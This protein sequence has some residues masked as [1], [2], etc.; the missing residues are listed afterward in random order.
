MKIR[1]WLSILISSFEHMDWWPDL[2]DL[3]RLNILNSPKEDRARLLASK[4]SKPVVDI[5][6][7]IG[8]RTDLEYIEDFELPENPTKVAF[9]EVDSQLLLFTY[10]NQRE[11][12]AMY[13]HTMATIRKNESMGFCGFRTKA[14]WRLGSPEK[15]SRAITENFGVGADSLDDEDF[16]RMVK[17]MSRMTWKIKMLL[18]FAL[19]TRLFN[20]RLWTELP[21]FILSLIRIHFRFVTGLTDSLCLFEYRI[22]FE[23]FRMQ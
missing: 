3:D 6:V 23:V 9:D 5:M 14:F 21:I 18:L 11:G 19:L 16:E 8:R 22:I 12:K 2:A 1:I 17:M 7:E 10:R 15:I 4:Y 20:V 13:C